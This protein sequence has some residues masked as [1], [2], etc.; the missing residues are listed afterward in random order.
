MPAVDHLRC[1]HESVAEGGWGELIA[2]RLRLAFIV[3]FVVPLRLLTD[4]VGK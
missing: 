2:S 4:L 1:A 3:R